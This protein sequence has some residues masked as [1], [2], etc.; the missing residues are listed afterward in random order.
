MK[1]FFKRGEFAK[2]SGVSLFTLRL[3]DRLDIL[4][5]AYTGENGYHFYTDEQAQ[6]LLIIQLCVKAGF[7]LK[8][9]R[10]LQK[11]P[12]PSGEMIRLFEQIQRRI[13]SQIIEL[14]SSENM[15]SSMLFYHR[16]WE[17]HGLNT[18][19]TERRIAFHGLVSDETD[20]RERHFL[21]SS[22]WLHQ[23]ETRLGHPIE[24]PLSYLIDGE[25]DALRTRMLLRTREQLEGEDFYVS[26]SCEAYMIEAAEDSM[27]AVPAR[28]TAL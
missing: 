10:Q 24:F 28:L 22:E 23:A 18:P 7:S 11:H 16:S 14:A 3:Y 19:F 17:E 6:Q 4:K 12:L 15:V 9:I 5:P 26:P 8:E 21:H 1:K 27:E 25:G 13:H 2:L 20:F